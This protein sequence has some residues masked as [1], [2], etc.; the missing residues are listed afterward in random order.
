[1]QAT[2]IP[3]GFFA[4][5]LLTLS[6]LLVAFSLPISFIV[7]QLV[8]VAYPAF[9]SA[10][11]LQTETMDDDKM[12]LTY[13]MAFGLFNMLDDTFGYFLQMI[14]FYFLIKLFVIIWL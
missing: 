14:P 10:L 2:N 6:V 9:K 11:A 12:W 3:A 8:S 7:V 5:G 1:M 13:W 4:L